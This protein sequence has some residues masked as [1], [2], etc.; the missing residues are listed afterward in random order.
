MGVQWIGESLSAKNLAFRY[1]SEAPQVRAEE[2]FSV[3]LVLDDGTIVTALHV[4]RDTGLRLI[5]EFRLVVSSDIREDFECLA[6]H[7]LPLRAKPLEWAKPQ[8]LPG[9]SLLC[10]PVDSDAGSLPK[11][12]G[13]GD[14]SLP[15]DTVELLAAARAKGMECIVSA[16]RFI[17][18]RYFPQGVDTEPH[19]TLE[20]SADGGHTW[21]ALA[22][23]MGGGRSW[24]TPAIPGSANSTDLQTLID[25]WREVPV[26]YSLLWEARTLRSA[27]A[28]LAL[29]VTALE[30]GTKAFIGLCVPDADWLLTNLQSPPVFKLLRD[31]LPQLTPP[32]G[33]VDHCN[34]LPGDILAVINQAVQA[35]NELLHRGKSFPRARLRELDHAVHFALRMLDF[36]SG[37]AWA[38]GYLG[39]RYMW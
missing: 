19:G 38:E 13:V 28:R 27:N 23:N 26:A 4:S 20:W 31:Y 22:R 34:A 37:E 1:S 25:R 39:Y 24:S 6:E 18:W 21:F 8:V 33:A 7:R 30:V 17:A 2:G 12:W 3:R 10:P 5:A 29:T 32:S 14:R 11:Y 9:G 36:Y 16:V 35:R 15:S